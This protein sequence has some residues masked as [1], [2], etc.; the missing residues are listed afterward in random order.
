[1][2]F[3]TLIIF[4]TSLLQVVFGVNKVQSRIF[5]IDFNVY[6]QATKT[7]YSGIN[8]YNQAFE[9]VPFNYPPS[10]FLIFAPFTLFNQNVAQTIFTLLS[11]LSLLAS[12]YFLTSLF[13][14]TSNWTMRLLITSAFLQNFPT[15][16]TLTLGQ[17][18]LVVLLLLVL[19][20][21]FD[22][23]KK[24][25]WSG[26]CFGL[27]SMI[28]LT[29]IV[30]GIYFLVQKRFMALFIGVGILFLSN[31]LFIWRIPATASFFQSTLPQLALQTG[32]GASLYDQSFRAFLSRIGSVSSSYQISLIIVF[33]L[34]ILSIIKFK[35]QKNDLVFF[36]LILA[37]TTIGSSFTWQHHLVFL[38]PGFVAET[39]YFLKLLT[40]SDG[41][42]DLIGDSSEVKELIIRGSLLLLSAT[43]VGYHFPDIAHPPTTNP[44][45]VSH[46]L[47]GTLIL[48]GL[49]LTHPL[50][51]F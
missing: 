28:K 2:K 11:L 29:P 22:Q 36:S 37:L 9:T 20:F 21:F 48:V 23:K 10:S 43:L 34:I 26:I 18:N 50:H 25:V 38:F 39:I 35:K 49:L 19:M 5:L 7:V 46:S 45:L 8:P 32:S 42:P 3:L 12:S 51:I 33:A 41:G 24:E 47:M 40:T 6:Y 17:V 31:F 1:M 13:P 14:A 44:F 15:K 27:A 30:L 4:L 16:F